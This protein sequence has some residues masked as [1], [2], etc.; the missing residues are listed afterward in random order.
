MVLQP[1]S[2]RR[3]SATCSA[4]GCPCHGNCSRLIL[5]LKETNEVLQ[6]ASEASGQGEQSS[7]HALRRRLVAAEER[8]R[9]ADREVAELNYDVAQLY[10]RLS[11]KGNR[12][13]VTLIADDSDEAKVVEQICSVAVTESQ[14]A[15]A[16]AGAR[17]DSEEAAA[18]RSATGVNR[19]AFRELCNAHNDAETGRALKT[20][21]MSG[22]LESIGVT[23]TIAD[24]L[25][26]RLRRHKGGEF[27]STERS[28][29]Q[30][31]GARGTR[32]IVLALIREVPIAEMLAEMIWRGAELLHSETK[33]AHA[34][35]TASRGAAP[36][37]VTST[38]ATLSA[39]TLIHKFH[40]DGGGTALGMA[41][42]GPHAMLHGLDALL[43]TAGAAVESD[44]WAWAS[45]S[46]SRMGLGAAESRAELRLIDEV[47]REHCERLDS[48]V[49]FSSSDYGVTTTSEIEYW[50]V[51]S[52]EKGL[53][54]IGLGAW[55]AEA[56]GPDPAVIALASNSHGHEKSFR[57]R[58]RPLREFDA[59]VKDVNARLAEVHSPP[60]RRDELIAARLLTSPMRVKYNATL[61]GLAANTALARATH[62]ELCAGD[63]ADG[64]SPNCYPVTLLL[65][66]SALVKLSKLATPAMV[67]RSVPGGVLP[68]HFWRPDHR[69]V[70]GGV[71]AG[72]LSCV[73]EQRIAQLHAA[74]A[75]GGLQSTLLAV[76]QADGECA[77]DISW[78]SEYPAEGEV[79][80]PPLTG[81]RVVR[82]RVNGPALML[83]V[84]TSRACVCAKP[85][86]VAPLP[87][88]PPRS[89]AARA[90]SAA[91][92]PSAARAPSAARPPAQPV[93]RDDGRGD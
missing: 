6:N 33:A 11:S 21:T 61:R 81:L 25:L 56:S 28:F 26:S 67:Y 30:A 32:Q 68:Q 90:P 65:I 9:R 83:E 23:N 92:V 45:S 7:I 47:R 34:P 35:P 69:G 75:R 88:P 87:P 62:T 42:S 60:L 27:P 55:P 15:A 93:V 52:P 39:P 66:N 48:R 80:F 40:A 78:L 2:G 76:H 43:E 5:L 44:V 72:V 4:C 79:A 29:A 71:E 86:P 31:L 73:H 20:W 59:K 91:R 64:A 13:D 58:P 18:G 10:E 49:R 41:S 37:S 54:H 51:V 1:A 82:S 89:A 50:F 8:V 63:L 57:R 46:A 19:E 84:C 74:R 70:L 14:A 38:S 36:H 24:A 85:P 77:A 22:W 16:E 3:L 53:S 17:A 12:R